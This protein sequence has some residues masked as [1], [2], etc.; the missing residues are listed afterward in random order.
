VKQLR[1]YFTDMA[2]TGSG[3]QRLG[4]T[5]ESMAPMAGYPRVYNIE[6][7]NHEDLDV[8]GLFG[9]T[10]GPALEEVF[11]YKKTLKAHPNPPAANITKF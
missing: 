8:A 1:F 7:D 4:G 6:M 10:V 9:W 2:H 5:S 3:T 11:R